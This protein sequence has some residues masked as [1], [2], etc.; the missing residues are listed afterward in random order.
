MPPLFR[1][2]SELTI[3]YL[4]DRRQDARVA[5][6]EILAK[7]RNRDPCATFYLS[8]TLAAMEHPSALQM[9]R[10]AVEE[11]YHCYSFYAQDPWLDSLRDKAEFNSVVRL[12]EAGYRDSAAAFGAAGGERLLGATE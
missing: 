10:R 6:D 11:G 5:A 3:A 7:W 8:R 12:A 9:F 4:E 2:F 1:L